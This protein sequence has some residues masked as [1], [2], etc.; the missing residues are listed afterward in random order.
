[1]DLSIYYQKYISGYYTAIL[2]I[3]F[4]VFAVLFVGIRS[5]MDKNESLKAKITSWILLI[6]LLT[7]VLIYF[8]IGPYLAKKDY[9]QKT[10]YYYEGDFEI[11][12][13]TH[14]Y[15]HKAV[16]NIDGQN[17]R[18]KYYNEN[19]EFEIVDTGKYNGKLV[20]SYYG[21]DVLY[22]EATSQ[23]WLEDY[24]LVYP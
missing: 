11:V 12:E 22:I 4:V 19:Y 10:I 24:E 23:E 8:F 6:V 17:I 21:A 20:Y 18:L 9:D 3:C 1:M 2:V 13:I 14:G 7:I 5:I 15:F 16:F